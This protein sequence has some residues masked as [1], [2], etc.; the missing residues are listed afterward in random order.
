MLCTG[1]TENETETISRTKDPHFIALTLPPGIFLSDMHQIF[2][3]YSSANNE[4]E[5]SMGDVPAGLE[6]TGHSVAR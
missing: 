5:C 2:V 4:P 3:S 6:G 1:V